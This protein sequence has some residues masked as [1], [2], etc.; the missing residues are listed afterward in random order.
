MPD[1][2]GISLAASARSGVVERVEY[3]EVGSLRASALVRPIRQSD[4]S[5]FPLDDELVLYEPE[6]GSTFVLNPTASFIWSLCDGDRTLE[7]V[8]EELAD[9]YGVS[10]QQALSDVAALLESLERAGFLAG[11]ETS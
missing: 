8:A 6:A 10:E 3:G 9:R 5:A 4:V 2:R 7:E 11:A 1:S